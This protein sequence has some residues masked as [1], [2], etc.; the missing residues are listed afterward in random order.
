M[1]LV[2]SAFF[3]QLHHYRYSEVPLPFTL[4]LTKLPFFVPTW[5]VS[6]SMVGSWAWRKFQQKDRQDR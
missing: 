3:S 4:P 5:W 6:C 2:N 1:Y